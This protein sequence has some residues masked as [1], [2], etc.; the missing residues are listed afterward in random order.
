MGKSIK[1]NLAK[2]KKYKPTK[3]EIEAGELVLPEGYELKKVKTVVQWIAEIEAEIA[4]I[5]SLKPPTEAELI[6]IGK[7]Y[8]FY[9]MDQRRKE[10]LKTE[11]EEL[12]KWL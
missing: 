2:E 1:D 6:I 9:Y 3:E 4:E 8:H 12:K 7:D 10:M 5:D 11:V